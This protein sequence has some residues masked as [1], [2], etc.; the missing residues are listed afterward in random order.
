[1][2]LENL[3]H[4]V[5]EILA[6]AEENGQKDMHR[7]RV[8]LNDGRYLIFYTFDEQLGEASE[9]E[10]AGQGASRSE[11]DVEPQAEEERRV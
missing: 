4:R 10:G 7:R 5:A 1:M 3:K 9:I 11:P 6:M 8:T 2:K